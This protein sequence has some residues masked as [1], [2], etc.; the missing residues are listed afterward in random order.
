MRCGFQG[1]R[2]TGDE[3]VSDK[4]MKPRSTHSAHD[5]YKED[6]WVDRSSERVN[7][8]NNLTHAL[9]AYQGRFKPQPIGDFYD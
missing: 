3:C 9:A 6:R 5:K 7:P 1:N 4:A 8:V 2:L